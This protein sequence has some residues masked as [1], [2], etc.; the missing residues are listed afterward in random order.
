M[1]IVSADRVMPVNTASPDGATDPLLK[2]LTLMERVDLAAERETYLMESAQYLF[3]FDALV[4]S[5]PNPP[6]E[7]VLNPTEQDNKTN[8]Q[9]QT[10]LDF[11]AS[12]TYLMR[13]WA[14]AMDGPVPFLRA[15]YRAGPDSRLARAASHRLGATIQLWLKV[16]EAALAAPVHVPY[17]P[18]SDRYEIEFWGCS[19]DVV[20]ASVDAKGRLAFES[21][22]LVGRPDLLQGDP[23]DFAREGVADR[24]VPDVTPTTAMHPVK[25]LHVELAWGDGSGTTWDSRDGANYHY[26]VAMLV[27]GW[28]HFLRVGTS[29]NPHGGPGTLEYRNLLTNYGPSPR[30][31]LGRT[32]EPWSCD[33]FGHKPPMR[34]LEPFLAV[35]YVDLHLLKP[36]S[37]IGLHRHR[38]NPDVFLPIEGRGYVVTGDWCKQDRRERCLEIRTL[39][40][41]HL[42]LIHGGQ[43]HGLMNPGTRD[44]ALFT[45]GGYD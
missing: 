14:H 35:H 43:L 23:S 41:G 13:G 10:I 25:P 1:Q 32:L 38:D 39:G 42:V 22:L 16:G 26:E 18:T 45:F 37:G 3:A 17:N 12:D 7:R 11:D 19:H 4:L 33:A 29:S 9:Q 2:L 15:S 44:L 24:Y 34:Q 30:H 8:F 31:E 40:A 28:E 6:D 21:G 5:G 36:G 20:R 27:R